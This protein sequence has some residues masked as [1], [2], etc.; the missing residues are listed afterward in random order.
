MEKGHLQEDG[1]WTLYTFTQK[2][3]KGASPDVVVKYI[4][5]WMEYELLEQLELNY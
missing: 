2:L 5:G 3:E 1:S 4:P